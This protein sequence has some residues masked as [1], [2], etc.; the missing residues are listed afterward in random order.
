MA[1]IASLAMLVAACGSTP[2][3]TETAQPATA[4]AAQPEA[5]ATPEPT[6]RPASPTV[7]DTGDTAAPEPDTGVALVRCDDLNP[8]DPGV[9]GGFGPLGGTPSRIT[10]D[11]NDYGAA[12]ADLWGGWWRDRPS[13]ALTVGIAGP[14]EEHQAAMA[15]IADEYGVAI[16]VVP[17]VHTMAELEALIPEMFFALDAELGLAGQGFLGGGLDLSINRVIVSLRDP[18]PETLAAVGDALPSAAVCVDIEYTPDPPDGPLR[19]AVDPTNPADLVTC[20][21]RTAP[22]PLGSLLDPVLAADIDHPAARAL[23]AAQQAEFGE[24]LPQHDWMVLFVDDAQAGF[25]KLDGRFHYTTF[26]VVR[27]TWVMESWNS[28][29]GGCEPEAAQPEGLGRVELQLDPDSLPGPDDTVITLLA[30]ERAC[31]GGRD[32]GDTLVGPELIETPDAVTVAYAAIPA[33]A[34]E[35]L[36]NPSTRV[37]IE[38]TGPLGD[39]PILDGWTVPPEQIAAP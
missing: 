35:C 19:V 11:L 17:V 26:E 8:P 36:E 34:D 5:T 31:A 29:P 13:G 20:G 16:G 24:A 22:F 23:A 6:A 14:V 38:L 18:S 37:Q 25:A 15:Q 2:D 12:N 9:I 1:T 30:T 10:R 28:S 21:G 39:R 3:R 7:N 4:T 27:A 32:L 33:L